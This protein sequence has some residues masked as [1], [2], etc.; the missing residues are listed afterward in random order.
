MSPGHRNE[1][2]VSL[3]NPLHELRSI[4]YVAFFFE[5][6]F[7]APADFGADI[8]VDVPEAANEQVALVFAFAGFQLLGIEAHDAAGCGRGGLAIAPSF[9]EFDLDVGVQVLISG[10][11]LHRFF[12][13]GDRRFEIAFTAAESRI[14]DEGIRSEDVVAERVEGLC[15]DDLR[16]APDEILDFE[17][18]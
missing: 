12:E 5:S 4:E 6:G 11:D 17:S 8:F 13:E 3:L 15:V 7:H 18:V 2:E 1:G 14:V 9:A 10:E 16:I